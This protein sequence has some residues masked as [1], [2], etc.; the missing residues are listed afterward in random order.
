MIGDI[1]IGQYVCGNSFLHR[2]DPRTKILSTTAYIFAL[3]LFDSIW[4]YIINFVLVLSFYVI[5]GISL[6]MVLNNVKPILPILILTSI[7]NLCLIQDG[8]V[9]FRMW[10]FSVTDR[11][12]FFTT[13]V[14]FRVILLIFSSSLLTYTTLPVDLTRGIEKLMKP[15]AKIRFPVEEV[16]MMISIAL[17]FVPTLVSEADKIISAQKSRGADMETGSLIKRAKCM[18]PILIPLF[19]CAF[20]RADELAVAMESRCYRVGGQRTSYKNL[21]FKKLDILF[22]LGFLVILTI[23]LLINTF[24]R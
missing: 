8:E 19:V 16:A 9:V 24:F 23:F 10:V 1:T 2:L 22:A 3:F 15:L 17:R 5:C 12:I 13:M 11:A 7:I 4:C 6:K 14:F 21:S 18:V 20:K